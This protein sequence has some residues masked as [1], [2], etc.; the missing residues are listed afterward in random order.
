MSVKIFDNF[1]SNGEFDM[2]TREIGNPIFKWGHVSK[3]G[4]EIEYPWLVMN[5][6]DNKFLNTYIKSKIEK[7]VIMTFDTDRIY[8]NGQMYGS[9]AGFHVDSDD[10]NGF[11]FLLFVHDCDEDNADSMGGYFYYKLNGEIRCIEPIKNRAVFFNSNIQHKGSAFNR[12]VG[13][14]RQSI[15]WKFHCNDSNLIQTVTSYDNDLISKEVSTV[16]ESCKNLNGIE[17]FKPLLSLLNKPYILN[18][19]RSVAICFK[20]SAVQHTISDLLSSSNT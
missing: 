13:T 18:C 12:Q 6:S 17:Q 2:L 1:L 8:M 14:L 16:F 19:D 3:L 4:S 11:T 10:A 9:E 15:A 7:T 20:D 5:L